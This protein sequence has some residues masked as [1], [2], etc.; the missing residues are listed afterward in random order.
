MKLRWI[1]KINQDGDSEKVLQFRHPQGDWDIYWQD[2]PVVD[3]RDELSRES[4][5]DA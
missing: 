1:I 3:K 2:V 5:D 4:G